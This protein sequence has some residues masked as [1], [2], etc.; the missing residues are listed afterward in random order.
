MKNIAYLIIVSLLLTTCQA[1]EPDSFLGTYYMINKSGF[2][3]WT[4][5][6][7]S[8]FN[9]KLFPDFSKKRTKKTSFYIEK[10]IHLEDRILLVNKD[11]KNEALYKT[12][13][14]LG[15]EEKEKHIKFVLNAIDT[16]S[17][18]KTII[19]LNEEDTNLLLGFNLYTREQIDAFASMR[20]IESMTISEFKNYLKALFEKM[21]LATSEFSKSNY[22]G[23]Y[24]MSS[25]FNFQMVCQVL[26]EI[27]FSPVQNSKTTDALFKKYME[28]P[29]IKELLKSLKN[30]Q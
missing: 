16:T 28:N 7:D 27:G 25:S 6:K 4:I 26:S 10:Q 2:V 13:M 22:N 12:Q 23:V 14:T 24:G 11:D 19:K 17:N 30:K 8:V 1:Q 5:T 15:L 3:E 9:Q 20:P 29:E 18:L 21:K